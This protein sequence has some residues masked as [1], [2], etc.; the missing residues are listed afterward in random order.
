MIDFGITEIQIMKSIKTKLMLPR[1]NYVSPDF[2]QIEDMV[3]KHTIKGDRMLNA[4][5]RS[6]DET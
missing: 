1:L 4:P 5:Q 3:F 6:V 2:S